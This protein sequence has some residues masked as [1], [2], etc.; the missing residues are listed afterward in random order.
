MKIVSKVVKFVA[1]HALNKIQ[2][3]LLLEEADS[4]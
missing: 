1:S 2:F 4:L 3:K